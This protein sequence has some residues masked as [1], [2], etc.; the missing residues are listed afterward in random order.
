M[1]LGTHTL[2]KALPYT[3]SSTLFKEWHDANMY[4]NEQLI[5]LTSR[6]LIAILRTSWNHG[7]VTRF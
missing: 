4:E 3:M 2:E 5:K 7:D 1:Y 6:Y